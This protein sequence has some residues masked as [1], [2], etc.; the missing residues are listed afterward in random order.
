MNWLSR[1]IRQIT[2]PV[3]G[4]FEIE[5]VPL[6]ITEFRRKSISV[7]LS[8]YAVVLVL[9]SVFSFAYN[10]AISYH[11]IKSAGVLAILL[12]VLYSLRFMKS[13]FVLWLVLNLTFF[14]NLAVMGVVDE[15]GL[16]VGAMAFAI[17]MPIK[18]TY[19]I[20]RVGAV[21]SW[22]TGMATILFLYRH[23][24]SL[25]PTEQY[26][27]GHSQDFDLLLMYSGALTLS[28]MIALILHQALLKSLK[29]SR[30]S[31]L[32]AR[33]ADDERLADILSVNLT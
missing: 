21:G 10:S 2:G 16:Q 33:Q 15:T 3:K 6:A 29:Q 14:A 12:I 11:D 1:Q 31:L 24:L 8:F 26:L 19:F 9:V 22:A 5:S 7:I 23:S 13:F 28:M 25:P 17:L 27:G 32:R 4:Y 18:S 20:G 30:A